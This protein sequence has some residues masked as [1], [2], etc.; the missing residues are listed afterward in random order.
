MAALPRPTL[1]PTAGEA[2]APL[3]VG[4]LA[5]EV[6]ARFDVALRA[7]PPAAEPDDAAGMLWSLLQTHGYGR[8]EALRLAA[9][10]VDLVTD[11]LRRTER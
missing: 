5:P 2:P 6:L 1:A 9:S 11:D 7:R 10:L 8:G 3:P 4:P